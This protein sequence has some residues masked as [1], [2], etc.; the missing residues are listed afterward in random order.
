MRR[1]SQSGFPFWSSVQ[2]ARSARMGHVALDSESATYWIRKRLPTAFTNLRVVSRWIG[3]CSIWDMLTEWFKASFF[4][5]LSTWAS[6][7]RV[8]RC[9]MGA[10]RIGAGSEAAR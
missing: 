2:W 4:E 7:N 8:E 10:D 3:F 5:R 9:S 6:P 1:L